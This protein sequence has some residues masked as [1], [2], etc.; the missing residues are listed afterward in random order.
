[1]TE[2][3]SGFAE[4]DGPRAFPLLGGTRYFGV[5][6][7]KNVALIRRWYAHF[8]ADEVDQLLAMLDPDFTYTSSGAF[9]DFDP[10]YRGREAFARWREVQVAPWEHFHIEVGE[11]LDRQ[12]RLIVE[13]RLR[14]TG[15]GSGVAVDQTFHHAWH[16][17]NGMAVR[18]DSRRTREQALK[19][20]GLAD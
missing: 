9:P 2:S 8:N 17:R 18:L 14:A 6:S 5:M 13:V 11:V 16:L 7:E 15:A 10:V 12:D 20:A 3:L 1:V 4:V 19:A